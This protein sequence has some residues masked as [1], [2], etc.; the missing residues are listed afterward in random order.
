MKV[1]PSCRAVVSPNKDLSPII[2]RDS[3]SSNHRVA[4]HLYPHVG[5]TKNGQRVGQRPF[6]VV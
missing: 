1:T 6:A 4:K 2:K 3:A 5:T